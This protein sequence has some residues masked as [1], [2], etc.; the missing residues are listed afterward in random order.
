M[1]A[2]ATPPIPDDA[3]AL[4]EEARQ[5]AR[6]RR[7]HIAA[8]LVALATVGVLLVVALLAHDRGDHG[9]GSAGTARPPAAGAGGDLLFMRVLPD[10]RLVRVDPR[11]GHVRVVPIQ[12][13][14]GDALFCLIATGRQL[15]ISDPGRTLAYAPSASDNPHPAQV[16]NGWITVP[17][18]TPGT[19]WLGI[20][21]PHQDRYHRR[22]SAVREVDLD[23]HVLR[24]MRPPGGRWPVE[25]VEDG[26]LFQAG[27][28]L[29]LWSFTTHRFTTRLPGA[30]PADAAGSTVASCQDPCRAYTVTDLR[31]G[32][33]QRIAPPAGYHWTGGYEGQF[34][35]DATH[36]ALPIT[37]TASQVRA[38][39]LALVNLASRTVRVIPG[40]EAVEPIYRPMTWSTSGQRLFFTT[41]TGAVR[42]YTPGATRSTTIAQ[43]PSHARAM[44]IV[45]VAHGN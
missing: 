33:A 18:Q 20:L 38:D 29:R 12:L 10:D 1:L 8:T 45:A 30:F 3:E 4:F 19:V 26:L 40:S 35:P 42:A 13:A 7:W 15:I 28:H 39:A 25:A 16:G 21:E 9:S 31:T 11:S 41:R 24:S 27:D 36:L 17:S 23:G 2:V 5:R 14:C 22:I 34:S 43:L 44:Q 32:N 37:D 6:R